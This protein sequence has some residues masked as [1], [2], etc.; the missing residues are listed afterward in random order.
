MSTLW[1][2]APKHTART[3]RFEYAVYQTDFLVQPNS[4]P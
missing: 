3:S 4:L 1:D 2:T